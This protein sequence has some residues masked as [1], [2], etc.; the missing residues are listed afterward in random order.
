MFLFSWSPLSPVVPCIDDSP[1]SNIYGDSVG[2]FFFFVRFGLKKSVCFFF[3]S[4]A[5]SEL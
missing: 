4:I 2:S 1:Y 5:F 3:H